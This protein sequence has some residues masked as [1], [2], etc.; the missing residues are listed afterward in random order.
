VDDEIVQYES[1]GPAGR[2]DTLLGCRRGAWGTGAAAHE[3]G[4]DCRRY[5]VDGCINGYII[6]QETTLLDETTSRLAHVFNTC[7]FDMLYFDGGEDVDRRRFNYYASHFQAAAMG[8]FRK[9][10][11]IH[12][13][14]VLTHGLWHSFTRSGTYDTYENTIRGR[15]IAGGTWDKLPTVREHIDRSVQRL[16]RLQADMLPAELGW[17]GI[18]PKGKATDGLQ[19]DEIE[20]LMARSLA[21]NAPISLQ[22]SFARMESHPLTPGILQIV[23]EYEQLRRAG[24]LSAADGERLRQVGRDFVLFRDPSGRPDGQA[25]FV[26]VKRLPIGVESNHMRC[27]LGPR[28]DDTVATVWHYLGREA[29]I[30]LDTQQVVPCGIKGDVIPAV[31]AQGRTRIAIG[32]YRTTLLFRHVDPAA[33]RRI[34]SDM[35]VELRQPTTLWIQAED[36]VKSAGNTA[37]GSAAGVEEEAFGDTVVCTGPCRIAASAPDYVEYRVEI[38]RSGRWTLWARVRYPRGGDDSFG[39]VRAGEPVTLAG[40]QVLGN[41]GAAGSK[42]HWT[43]RGGGVTSQP[44]GAPVTFRLDPGPFTFRVHAREG[45]GSQMNNPRLDLM[46]LTEDPDYVPSDADVPVE[47]KKP[48]AND[49]PE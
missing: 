32:P 11:L 20:Y 37:R 5:G 35:Q 23:R 3:A 18:W 8:K 36:F 10:P 34:L 43:G 1:I 40:N 25:E 6:D 12:M 48:T 49:S 16:V 9:R 47:L 29:T 30:S 7:D 14:T 44:P 27:L 22:T 42:W 46:C 17:F 45:G 21:Y 33:A 19:L 13:G 24:K 2:W 39:I 31:T 4:T 28:G 38:P 41:C 26:Q 15:I